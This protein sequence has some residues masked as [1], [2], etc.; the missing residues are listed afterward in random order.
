MPV[1]VEGVVGV[2]DGGDGVGVRQPAHHADEGRRDAV[3]LVGSAASGRSKRIAPMLRDP[4]NGMSTRLRVG[5]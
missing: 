4:A 2:R 5:R 1:V 3:D